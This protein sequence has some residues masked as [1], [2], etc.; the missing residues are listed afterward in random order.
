M[1]KKDVWPWLIGGGIA[2][3]I[4]YMILSPSTAA[5]APPAAPGTTPST[6]AALSNGTY[7][8]AANQNAANYDSGETGNTVYDGYEL[9]NGE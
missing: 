4:L 9:P 1:A 6:P 2:A 7:V 5:A 3:G 8:P